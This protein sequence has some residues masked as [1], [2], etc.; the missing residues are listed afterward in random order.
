[1]LLLAADENFNGNIVRGLF[2]RQ[3]ALDLVRLQ[4]VGLSGAEDPV[5]LA[6]AAQEGR[7]LLTHDVS[8]LTRDTYE[9]V[10]AGQPMPGVFEVR[11]DLPIGRAIE[12]ILL[13][14]ECSLEGEWEGQIRY[15]PLR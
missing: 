1:M 9:R 6:W 5:V 3:P 7:V 12:E 10:Q 4:D 8:T 11:H 15:L 2:R 13:L 14:V